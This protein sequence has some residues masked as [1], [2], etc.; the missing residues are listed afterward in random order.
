VDLL[1]WNG[2]GTEQASGDLIPPV[3]CGDGES[4]Y[5]GRPVRLRGVHSYLEL[6]EWKRCTSRDV[7]I[8]SNFWRV[9]LVRLSNRTGPSSLTR[10]LCS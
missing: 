7:A 6:K 10:L 3:S 4:V 5:G 9:H 2:V 1:V 8:G